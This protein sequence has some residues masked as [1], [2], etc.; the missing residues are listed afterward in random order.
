VLLSAKTIITLLSLVKAAIFDKIMGLLPCSSPK[1]DKIR[2][3]R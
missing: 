2:T 3:G 1:Q